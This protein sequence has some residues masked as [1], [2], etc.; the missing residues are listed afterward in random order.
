M[1]IWAGGIH[2][3]IIAHVIICNMS[4]KVFDGFN[5]GGEEVFRGEQARAVIRYVREEYGDELEFLWQDEN[6]IWRNPQNRKWYGVMMR[7][8]GE[9]LGLPIEKVVEIIDLRF[10]KG[11]AR[12]FVGSSD[13]DGILPGYHMNKSNWITVVLDYGVPMKEILALVDQSY[14]IVAEGR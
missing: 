12:E 5:V 2:K 3:G 4:E 1:R 14:Q 7:V 9:K 6:G 10:E 13:N 8:R 11:A